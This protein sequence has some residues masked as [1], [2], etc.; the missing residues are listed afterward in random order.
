MPTGRQAESSRADGQ[1]PV[2]CE[3]IAS[4]AGG[5]GHVCAA[6]GADRPKNSQARNLPFALSSKMR[7]KSHNILR[8]LVLTK[9][10]GRYRQAIGSRNRGPAL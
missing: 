10:H 7:N 3:P 5:K 8:F 1:F 4:V 9:K 6:E 2:L